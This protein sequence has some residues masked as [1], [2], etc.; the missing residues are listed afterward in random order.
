MFPAARPPRTPSAFSSNASHSTAVTAQ[1]PP[2]LLVVL[3]ALK[4]L[5]VPTM[6]SSIGNEK[7]VF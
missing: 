5:A 4:K 7:M 6:N 2:R 1:Y 3:Y